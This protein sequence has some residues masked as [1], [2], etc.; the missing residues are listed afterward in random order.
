MQRQ[1]APPGLGGHVSAS[2]RKEG[3]LGQIRVQAHFYRCSW[4]LVGGALPLVLRIETEAKLGV[5]PRSYPISSDSRVND[6]EGS[7]Q[8][9]E[10]AGGIWV[11]SQRRCLLRG[12]VPTEPSGRTQGL[13]SKADAQ[14]R[15]RASP[16]QGRFL[17]APTSP[18]P[19]V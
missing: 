14:K 1:G 3:L 16:P 12:S 15:S 11:I 4:G 8:E 10:G 6:S 7:R 17:P 19:D 18:C 13:G 5:G 2:Q 9:S